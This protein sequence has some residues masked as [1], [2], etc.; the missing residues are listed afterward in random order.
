MSLR[1]S[2]PAGRFP[3]FV[4]PALAIALIG[5]WSP[6][7]GQIDAPYVPTPA[8]VVEAMLDLAGVSAGDTVLDLGSGDGRMVMAAADRGAYG[9]GIELQE[10]LVERSWAEARRR[11][12]EDRVRF[13][14]G[15]VLETEWGRPSVVLLYL[16]PALLRVLGPRLMTALP[17]GA[18]VV[19]H[20]FRI[21]EW[22]P[23]RQVSLPDVEGRERRLYLWVVPPAPGGLP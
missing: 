4:G 16:S 17:A 14:T 12:L 2:A 1:P 5:G 6:A 18:R 9:L 11:G 8:P 3:V 15:D 19:S 21:P 10:D 13:V 23:D 20:A 7:H 22:P